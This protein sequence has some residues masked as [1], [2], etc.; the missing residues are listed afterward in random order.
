MA[1]SKKITSKEE[2]GRAWLASLSEEEREALPALR[3]KRLRER[4]KLSARECAEY[5]DMTNAT[6]WYVYE[7]PERM[8]ERKIPYKVVKPM[9]TLMVGLG[10]PAVTADE[11]IALTEVESLESVRNAPTALNTNPAARVQNLAGVFTNQLQNATLLP[12]KYRVEKSVFL[13]PDMILTRTFGVGPIAMACDFR[14]AQSCCIVADDDGG[15]DYPAGTVL[16]LVDPVEYVQHQLVGRKVVVSRINPKIDLGEV[17]L[18]RVLSIEGNQMKLAT[19]RGEPIDGD[20]LGV[21]V[22]KYARE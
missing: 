7:T 20:I 12:V 15:Q 4:A 9:L 5:A 13:P 14:S 18:A 11:L 17:R 10:R 19:L 8:R 2:E 3:L 6:S 16:H 22:G 1:A 21:V